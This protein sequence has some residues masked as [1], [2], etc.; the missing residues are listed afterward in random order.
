MLQADTFG[1]SVARILH[2]QADEIRERRRQRAQEQSQKLP[3]KMLFPMVLCIFPATL[4]V[5]VLPGML[6][7]FDQLG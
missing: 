6:Q 7:V 4:V 1:V 2:T 5:V 3:V